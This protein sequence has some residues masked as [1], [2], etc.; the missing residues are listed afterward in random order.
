MIVD[1]KR[2][3]AYTVIVDAIDE[4]EG[5][6]NIALATVGGWK[7]IVKKEEFKPGDVAVFFEID[8]KLP[9]INRYEFMARKHYKVKTMKLGKFNVVSQGLL[10]PLSEFPELAITSVNLKDAVNPNHFVGI[11]LT[12]VL[13]ITYA[14]AEDNKRKAAPNSNAK[15]Q[16]MA[17]RHKKIFHQKWARWMMRREWGRKVMF[18]IFGRKKD[19]PKYFP[20][21][22]E[23]VHPT[24]EERV[25]NMPYILESDEPWVRTTKLDGTSTTFILERKKHR[26][27][28]DKEPYEFYVCSRN[29]RQL[30]PDQSCYHDSNVYWEMAEKYKIKNQMARMLDYHPNWD[31]VAIQG[32]TVG[33]SVQG[34]PHKLT[35]RYFY[36]FNFITSDKG[37]WDS[38]E[39]RDYIMYDYGI[40]WVP[41]VDTEYYLPKDM[42][43][44]KLSAD[45]PCELEGATGPREGYVYRSMD[46]KRSFKNVSR[47]YLLKH[48]G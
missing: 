17:T 31:Y 48:H 45:G 9:E 47:E 40:D 44:M 26:K 25:E 12:D 38:V 29:V 35:G 37:R 27:L 39:A 20:K 3:L 15:Y 24:D 16:S 32:E 43:E 33:E 22:F 42:E 18:L 41:I 21:H 2:A 19:N 30:D 14:E 8:S 1:G 6:D 46:G 13:H 34:N 5:A 23:F 36:A 28:W 10:M 7:V 11:D 4:I